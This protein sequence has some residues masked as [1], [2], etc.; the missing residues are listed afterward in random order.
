MRLTRKEAVAYL[1]AEGYPISNTTLGRIKSEL[2]RN[3]LSRMHK[4][5]AYEFHEQHL[6]RIDTCELI[7]KLMWQEYG[8]ETSP[9]RRVLILKE[10]KELQ[11]YL[12]SYYEATKMVLESKYGT[13]EYNNN[14]NS[15]D[16]S[17]KIPPVR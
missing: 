12:S 17:G 5:A 8:K 3:S 16:D 1:N 6:N 7:C 10:I 11:P 4:V 2:K 9:Y 13:A 15:S 14:P